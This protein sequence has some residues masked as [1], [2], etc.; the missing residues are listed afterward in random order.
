MGVVDAKELL[1]AEEEEEGRKDLGEVE[2]MTWG[3]DS[4]WEAVKVT[5]EKGQAA[6]AVKEALPLHS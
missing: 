5:V 4:A 3:G 2:V 6:G 1:G